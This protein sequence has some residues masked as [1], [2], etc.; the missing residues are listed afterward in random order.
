VP[1]RRRTPH[2]H[3]CPVH[4]TLKAR[5]SVP[6]LRHDVIFASI[7]AA[8]AKAS[9]ERFRL[10]QFSVQRDHVHLLLE[11]DGALR[12]RRGVQGLTIRVAKAINRTLGRRGSVWDDRYHA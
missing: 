2:D 3:R 12:L 11:A 5:A 6:S 9:S 8:F 4:V 1:H 7:R 10:L